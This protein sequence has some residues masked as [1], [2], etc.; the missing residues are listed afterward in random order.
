[1]FRLDPNIRRYPLLD[2]DRKGKFYKITAFAHDKGLSVTNTQ[3]K[4]A[5]AERMLL[6]SLDKLRTVNIILVIDGTQGMEKYFDAALEAIRR[7]SEYFGKENRKVQAGVVI[8]RDYTDGQYVTEYLSMRNAKDVSISDFLRKGGKYGVKSSA[9]DATDTEALYKGLEVALDANKMGYSP[10]N[11]N[12]MFVIGD[13]G[14]DPSD[15]RC[16]SQDEI[17]KKCV[18]NRIQLLPFQVRNIQSLADNL[19]RKQMGDIVVSNM[20]QQ[21][22]KLGSGI[23]LEYEDDKDGWDAKFD[24]AKE[25]TFFIGGMRFAHNNQELDVSR[26]YA[27]VM[28]TSN[29]FNAVV[30]NQESKLSPSVITNEAISSIDENFVKGRIG[31][32][33]LKALR[34]NKY[35]MAFEGFTPQKSHNER[36]YYKPVIYISH[37]EL[38]ALMDQLKPVLD[39]A[40]NQSD[41]RKPYVDAMKGLVRS[42][43]PD[44][45]ES[46]MN[47]MDNTEVMNRIMGLNVRTNALESHSIIDIQSEQKVTKEQYDNLISQFLEH[48]KKL[49]T[50]RSTKYA[51][52]TTQNGD[53]WYW[54]PAEDLP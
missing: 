8:Y 33:E 35:L 36:D 19:F 21:Y 30:E 24:V 53:R 52:S 23:K 14:N 47:K 27:L 41:N 1:M 29:K 40:Q 11:S 46:E 45:S 15:S 3:M 26:L 9:N 31:A 48:Y 43:L 34:E 13:C 4:A 22:S 10:D 44:I 25:S 38:N 16:L 7:A 51:F 42:M 50:I 54:I 32:A 17:T 49:E 37:K 5:E 39:A 20:K 2:N 12:L 6:E 28:S 18:D